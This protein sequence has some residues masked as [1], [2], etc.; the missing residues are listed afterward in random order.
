MRSLMS[1]LPVVAMDSAE[2]TWIGLVLTSFGTAM[3]DPVTITSSTTGAAASGAGAVCA[4]AV[5]VHAL[6]KTAMS[7]STIIE[8]RDFCFTFPNPHPRCLPTMFVLPKFSNCT[9]E[10]L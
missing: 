3:R 1:V 4:V 9:I 5:S 10:I 7:T 8:N 6:A 2:T